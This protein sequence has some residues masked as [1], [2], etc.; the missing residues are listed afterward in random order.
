MLT[1]TESTPVNSSTERLPTRLIQLVPGFRPDADG[2]G[3]CALALG[4]A[5]WKLCG[6]PTDFVVW[7]LA[8]PVPELE[9][10]GGEDFPHKIYRAEIQT[11]RSLEQLLDRT[12]GGEP[13]P[14][15]LLHYTSYA[16][17]SQGVAWWLP[18]L[19]RRFVQR[20]GKVVGFFHELY[21]VGRFP[22]KTWMSSGWQRH[23]FGEVLKLCTA[24]ITSNSHYL[25]QMQQQNARGL[26][27]VQSGVTS[28]VGELKSPL[29][30]A[31]RPKRLAIFGHYLGR[32]RL[33]EQH[34]PLLQKL[35]AHLSIVEVADI[36]GIEEEGR[37]LDWVGAQLNGKFKAHGL[38]S[39]DAVGSV[40]TNSMAGAVNY[41]YAR[42]FKSGVVGAY[43]AYGLPVILFHQEGEPEPVESDI[44]CPTPEQILATPREDLGA[45]LERAGSAGYAFYREH[46]S[47][48]SVLGKIL[49][50]LRL[51]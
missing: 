39:A 27:L 41:G 32:K 29:Q 47:H 20:G 14:V 7:R 13:Q 38:L 51:E 34:M 12:V 33:Y 43:Q 48:D 15:M 42:R 1:M 18:G 37:V 21:A 11:P 46:R 23:I 50:W 9:I 49:P 4:D 5:L 40:L 3:D 45:V 25:E 8:R 17:S 2:L 24:G 31:G 19:L 30:F 35:V 10:P 28:N 44:A 6:V 26:P 16:F 22:S 36:G